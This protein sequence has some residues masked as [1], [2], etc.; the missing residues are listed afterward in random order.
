M[1]Q[2]WVT[3]LLLQEL[4]ALQ[5]GERWTLPTQSKR[6]QRGGEY[7]AF[8]GRLRSGLALPDGLILRQLIFP[9]F[10]QS[11]CALRPTQISRLLS[12]ENRV[13]AQCPAPGAIGSIRKACSVPQEA[14]LQRFSKMPGSLNVECDRSHMMCMQ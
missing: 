8:A 2:F 12:L 7:S 3:A 5:G 1:P 10:P 4:K 11:S 14:A 9:E 13:T 6:V